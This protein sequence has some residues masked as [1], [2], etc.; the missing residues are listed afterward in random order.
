MDLAEAYRLLDTFRGLP[1]VEQK[2]HK[3]KLIEAFRALVASKP[4]E[5]EFARYADGIVLWP[6]M[7]HILVR[8]A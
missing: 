8:S 3:Q 2:A 4:D 1:P 6:E 7:L 5:Q